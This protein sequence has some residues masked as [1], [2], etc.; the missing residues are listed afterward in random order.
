MLYAYNTCSISNE[1]N[2]LNFIVTERKGP[3]WRNPKYQLIYIYPQLNPYDTKLS[4]VVYSQF[5][6]SRLNYCLLV[7][8]LVE[9]GVGLVSENY[10]MNPPRYV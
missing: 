4:N 5:Q 3:N 2:L 10:I 9:P 6:L 8:E 1:I 7:F